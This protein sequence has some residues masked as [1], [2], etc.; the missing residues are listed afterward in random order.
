MNLHLLQQHNRSPVR[1]MPMLLVTVVVVSLL[2]LLGI[3]LDARIADENH[4]L[5]WGQALFLLLACVTH[6]RRAWQ[7]PRQSLSFVIHTGLALLMYAFLLRELEIDQFGDHALW[8]WIERFF[9][10]IDLALWVVFFIFLAPRFRAVLSHTRS[11]VAMPVFALTVIGGLFLIA[12]WPFDKA[13]FHALSHLTNELVEETLELN[14]CLILF[15]GALADTGA[16]TLTNNA[17]P[18]AGHAR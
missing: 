11:I 8:V 17:Q 4:L 15:L 5:E 14:G 16:A 7:A 9:R 10:A 18:R 6:G 3:Q 2:C 13:V 1:S 12:G